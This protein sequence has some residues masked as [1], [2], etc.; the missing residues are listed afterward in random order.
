MAKTSEVF[1]LTVGLEDPAPTCDAVDAFVR[2]EAQ[3]NGYRAVP[4]LPEAIRKS[5]DIY[6]GIPFGNL[7]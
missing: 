3:L 2:H 6:R 1:A 7:T 5:L 4:R